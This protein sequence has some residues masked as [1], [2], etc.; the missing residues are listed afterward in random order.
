[1]APPSV[2]ASSTCTQKPR[3]AKALAALAPA[4]PLPKTKIGGADCTW[5][6]A[7]P[8]RGW[9]P[10]RMGGA[11]AWAGQAEARAGQAVSCLWRLGGRN[12]CWRAIVEAGPVGLG[13]WPQVWWGVLRHQASRAV[14]EPTH[15]L[16]CK[17]PWA[18]TNRCKP[19]SNPQQACAHSAA[20]GPNAGPSKANDAQ[21]SAL[22]GCSVWASRCKRGGA[23]GSF[24]HR[25]Q[26]LSKASCQ[27][28]SGRPK[29]QWACPAQ[30][31]V[32]ASH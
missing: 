1:M 28:A 29:V 17:R 27:W 21:S 7:G 3:S 12:T 19:G 5:V 8:R 25:A 16:S 20:K 2:P 18:K 4:K 22:G 6:G 9:S 15:R 23:W 31:G 13:G 30:A 14:L 10:A 32:S 24:S 11:E 26:V